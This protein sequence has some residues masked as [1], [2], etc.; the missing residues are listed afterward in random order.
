MSKKYT[1]HSDQF[2]FKVALEALKGEKTM[3]ELCQEFKIA[4]SQ[5][6]DW[7]KKLEES[8]PQVFSAKTKS[9]NTDTEIERLHATIGKLKVECDFLAKALGR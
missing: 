1:S 4:A 7:K 6:Y 8:G 5:I 9:I 3:A 2:K